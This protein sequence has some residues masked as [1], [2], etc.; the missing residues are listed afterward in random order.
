LGVN[1]NT[2]IHAI[3]LPSILAG[4]W[5]ISLVFAKRSFQRIL[6]SPGGVLVVF[7]TSWFIF[8]S[9]SS[10]SLFV[11]L[12]L[13]VE[14]F[15]SFLLVLTVVSLFV[16]PK[17]AESYLNGFK[18]VLS[19]FKLGLSKYKIF[20]VFPCIFLYVI[21]VHNT[22]I[23]R[24]NLQ[25]NLLQNVGTLHTGRYTYLGETIRAC[26]FV[27]VV[28][29][30]LGQTFFSSSLGNFWP[31]SLVE[32]RA[33]IH[34]LSLMS[35]LLL[36][37][38]ALKILQPSI[39]RFRLFQSLLV[40]FLGA[41]SLSFAY[42]LVNDSGNPI[43]LVGY[44]DTLFGIFLV[45]FIPLVW[46]LRDRLPMK[47]I[48]FTLLILILGGLLSSPQ[49]LLLLLGCLPL[50]LIKKK[51]FTAS[52]NDF[53]VNV[54]AS[55][56]LSTIV[57]H[58]SIGMLQVGG[59]KVNESIPGTMNLS[60]KKFSEVFSIENLSPGM[61]FLV[62][63]MRTHSEIDP[64]II[65]LAKNARRDLGDPQRLIW[66]LE[67]IILSSLRIIFWPCLGLTLS[68]LL[69]RR[70][71][72]IDQTVNF[73]LLK[74]LIAF[75]VPIFGFGLMASFFFAPGN[76]KWEMSRFLFPSL[77]LMSTLL[78]A[79]L[80]AIHEVFVQSRKLIVIL[81]WLLITPTIFF[82][83]TALSQFVNRGL[84]IPVVTTDLGP[85]GFFEQPLQVPCVSW[86][87]G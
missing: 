41:Y 43:S 3:S 76:A 33:L 46:H 14:P 35:L 62:G 34:F 58:G 4:G 11:S 52:R 5:V 28:R 78:V 49:S 53:A 83:S 69:T 1:I 87:D 37:A 61:P 63:D 45:L 57:W 2:L 16:M 26:N 66:D 71:S 27:P 73:R 17:V 31:Y 19:V 10:L 81:S 8:Y 67:Q 77:V 30:N 12:N 7:G 20:F 51:S 68:V 70:K 82:T 60:V 48:F 9:L 18:W 29:E 6:S 74:T 64:K 15:Y 32:I 86:L 24:P 65:D 47:F 39:S 44:A 42:T 50:L 22:V 38:G 25:D 55:L 21:V 72:L 13:K 84:S 23:L 56:L 59:T 36:F 85:I 54:V 80:N 79:S 40:I 75:A